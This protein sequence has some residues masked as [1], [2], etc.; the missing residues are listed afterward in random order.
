[1]PRKSLNN[2]QI[3]EIILKYLYKSV[4]NIP[5]H[6]RKNYGMIIVILIRLL[7]TL[8]P[9]PIRPLRTPFLRPRHFRIVSQMVLWVPPRPKTTMT[10]ATSRWASG[11][12]RVQTASQPRS[13]TRQTR[14][15]D[16]T[17][18]FR[19]SN[20]KSGTHSFT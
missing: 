8:K 17:T 18:T 3:R 9:C 10:A 7:I 15:R 14:F 11:Q 4:R 12:T 1:M 2:L 19:G 13:E 20:S 5:K 16:S 6:L